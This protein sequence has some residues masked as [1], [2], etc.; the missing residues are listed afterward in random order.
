MAELINTEIIE[1]IEN[2][3]VT[4]SAEKLMKLQKLT[5]TK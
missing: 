2:L 1:Y 4:E 3:S 5:I